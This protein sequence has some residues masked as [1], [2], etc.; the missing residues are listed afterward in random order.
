M[1]MRAVKYL[2]EITHEKKNFPLNPEFKPQ[3][4]L[5][6]EF[7]PQSLTPECANPNSYPEFKVCGYHRL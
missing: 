1:I 4:F 2:C 5:N 3:L 6:P 7:K